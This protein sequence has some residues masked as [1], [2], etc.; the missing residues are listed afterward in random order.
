MIAR[1]PRSPLFPYPPLSR[2]GR[3]ERARRFLLSAGPDETVGGQLQRVA[4]PFGDHLR[5]VERVG[6]LF[7][8][9]QKAET[10]IPKDDSWLGERSEEHTSELQS[11]SNLVCRL[12]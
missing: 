2:S 12:L 8:E 10:V 6:V 5:P 7:G 9:D 3:D 1:P 11:Q 4:V